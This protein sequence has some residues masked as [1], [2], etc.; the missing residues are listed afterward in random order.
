M[1]TG[2]KVHAPDE[3]N[4]RTVAVEI[5]FEESDEYTSEED[6]LDF[7]LMKSATKSLESSGFG[8]SVRE[9]R[10]KLDPMAQFE[11]RMKSK[12]QTQTI[13]RKL[14]LS[15]QKGSSIN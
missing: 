15:S 12:L 10:R 7:A 1:K 9:K 13:E 8:G 4:K 2:E 11:K 3:A 5:E 14:L 6:P